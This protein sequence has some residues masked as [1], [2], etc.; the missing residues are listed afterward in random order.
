MKE[1][2]REGVAGALW[3][4]FIGGLAGLGVCVW[5]LTGTPFFP[6]DTILIGTAACGTLGFV[7]GEPFRRWIEDHWG[8]FT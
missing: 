7:I 2:L 8:W 5:V 1:R 3:G 6:G 4:A